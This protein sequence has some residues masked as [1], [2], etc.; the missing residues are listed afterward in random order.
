MSLIASSSSRD[1]KVE[2]NWIYRATSTVDK[3]A[4]FIAVGMVA[5][6]GMGL[7]AFLNSYY[8]VLDAWLRPSL[9]SCPSAVHYAFATASRGA[10]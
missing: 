2:F 6:N 5:D 1:S 8:T 4:D 9:T 3:I 7:V 10:P